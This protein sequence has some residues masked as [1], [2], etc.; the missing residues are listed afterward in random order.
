M[1]T[2]NVDKVLLERY[3]HLKKIVKE[4][5]K[6]IKEINPKIRE[7][8]LHTLE[9]KEETSFG[10]FYFVTMR[11]W[12]YPDSIVKKEEELTKLQEEAQ[13]KGWATYTERHDLKFSPKKGTTE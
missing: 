5:E 1:T 9:Q 8:L 10:K 6:E 2:Q 3:A 7:Q 11:N 4:A 13:Q 12:I